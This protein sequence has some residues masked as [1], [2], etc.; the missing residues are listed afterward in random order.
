MKSRTKLVYLLCIS[1]FFSLAACSSDNKTAQE[2]SSGT[3]ENPEPDLEKEWILV[4]E[5]NFDTNLSAWNVW[6][7][8]AFNNEIQLYNQ[9]QLNIEEGVLSINASRN[10]VTGPTTPFDNTEKQF[11]YV[12]GRI[13]SKE[14]YGPSDQE[15]EKEY[16]IM[17][18]IQ[19]P[20][21]NGMWPAFWTFGDPWPTLGEIDIL[22]ARGNQPKTFQSNIFYGT[23]AGTPITQH[24]F[25]TKTYTVSSDLTNGFHI[26]ELIWS[27]T[28]LIIKLDNN[29]LGTYI[30]DENNYIETIFGS[31]HK[32]ILNLAVGGAFFSGVDPG[33]FVNNA[34]MKVDWVKV[35]KR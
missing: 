24:Q 16:R 22:E 26:Y 7:G 18:K 35:Y 15:G 4:W 2:S 3:G 32:I 14:F 12:S 25:T 8:G 11:Q 21:G 27:K 34:V 33:I 29:I 9:K 10:E 17:A 30:A 6:Y 31:Q 28:N 1:T 23:E 13:E 5:D 19:L 20:K